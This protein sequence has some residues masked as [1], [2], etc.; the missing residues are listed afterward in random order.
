MLDVD[1]DDVTAIV[2]GVF[3]VASTVLL[4]YITQTNNAV[5]PCALAVWLG[6]MALLGLILLFVGIKRRKQK[7]MEV[8][9]C[10][11]TS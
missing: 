8:I 9:E 7:P 10:T 3:F 11:N 5:T 2:M 1:F 4:Y 6:A